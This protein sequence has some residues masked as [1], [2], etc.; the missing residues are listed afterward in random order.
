VAVENE[1]EYRMNIVGF[2]V[3]WSVVNDVGRVKTSSNESE[4]YESAYIRRECKIDG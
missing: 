4:E 1:M 2:G 3:W